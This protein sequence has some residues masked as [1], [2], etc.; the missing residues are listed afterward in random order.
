MDKF[1]VVVLRVMHGWMEIGDITRERLHEAATITHKDLG[2]DTVV[3][4]TVPFTN[5]VKTLTTYEGV[6]MANAMIR[7]T[8]RTWHLDQNDTTAL[9]L[10]YETYSNHVIWSNARSMGYDVSDPLAASDSTFNAEGTGFLFERLD[11]KTWPPSIPQVCAEKPGAGNGTYCDRNYLFSDGM[12]FCTKTLSARIGAGLACLL[13]CAYNRH[14][15]TPSPS[16]LSSSSKREEEA[17]NIGGIRACE[18]IAHIRGLSFAERSR[19][20]NCIFKARWNLRTK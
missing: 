19:W 20:R 8:V 12:H 7:D 18:R 11:Q 17:R 14:G 5:N 16:S 1:D 4:I 10:D 2:A 13:G 9:V 3:F 15:G 6:S